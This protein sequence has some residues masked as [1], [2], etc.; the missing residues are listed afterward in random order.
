MSTKASFFAPNEPGK[1]LHI[2][3]EVTDDGTPS[4]TH[5]QCIIMTIGH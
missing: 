3:L 5:Y 4:L 1:Q 2:I